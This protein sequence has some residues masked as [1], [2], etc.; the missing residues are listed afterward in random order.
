M[1]AH[2]SEDE[3]NFIALLVFVFH[4]KHCDKKIYNFNS[5][6]SVLFYQIAL[7]IKRCHMLMAELSTYDMFAFLKKNGHVDG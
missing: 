3:F 7:S 6:H 5:V 1:A 4:S 2:F